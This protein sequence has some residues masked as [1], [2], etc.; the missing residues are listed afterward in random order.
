MTTMFAASE[1]LLLSYPVVY[2]I[3]VREQ[4]QANTSLNQHH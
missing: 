2:V 3:G 1:N 4:Y